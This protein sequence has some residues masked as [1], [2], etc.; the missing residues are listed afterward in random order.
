MSN[1]KRSKLSRQYIE[2]LILILSTILLGIWAVKGTIALRNILLVCGM[3]L[4]IYYIKLTFKEELI[5]KQIISWKILPIFLLGLVFLWVIIHYSF[6]SLDPKNQLNELSGTWLRTLF[7]SIVGLGTGMALRYHP[8]RLVILWTGIL[9]SFFVLLYQY[10]PRA[11]MQQ[12]LM[13]LDYDYYIFHL[14]IN[15]VLAGMILF[16]G[17]NGALQDYFRINYALRSVKIAR[18]IVFNW[19]IGSLIVLWSFVYIVNSRNGIGLSIILCVFWFVYITLDLLMSKSKASGFNSWK[20]IALMMIGLVIVSYFTVA[21]LKVNEG[22]NSLMDDAKI[23]LQLDRYPNWA[24]SELMGFPKD[25][26]GRILTKASNNY[27]RIAWALAGSRAILAYPIGVGILAYPFAKHPSAP[28]IMLMGS[29]KAGIATHSGWVELGLA[30]GLPIL[31]LI[32]LAIMTIFLICIFEK[33]PT[34]MTVLSFLILITFLY[35]TGE[36]AIDH[37]L[38]ILFYLLFFSASLTLVFKE[39]LTLAK[40][41]N[42]LQ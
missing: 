26:T 14:K 37:G 11:L 24:N 25:E 16:V 28:E 10:I 32:F 5:K 9:I 18:Y 33:I 8:R 21:Q 13:V 42:L 35:A 39:K 30:F 31:L 17:L 23:A 7:A 2:W 3:L 4:S 20:K 40:P 38:E 6:F 15:T 12:K 29:N 1:L 27:E 34:K 19:L 22:W 36:V 41:I